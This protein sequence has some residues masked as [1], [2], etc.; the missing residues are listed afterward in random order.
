MKI[1]RL[2]IVAPVLLVREIVA[3]ANHYRD[4]L[5]FT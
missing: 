4:A 5:G 3:A 2:T 1:A